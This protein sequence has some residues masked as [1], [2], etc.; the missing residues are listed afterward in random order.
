MHG[1]PKPGGD[2]PVDQLAQ[3][4]VAAVR[5]VGK[6]ASAAVASVIGD[7][8]A[9]ASENASAIRELIEDEAEES[10]GLAKLVTEMA[11]DFFLRK[12]AQSS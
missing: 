1:V 11:H 5:E 9:K 2:S 10:D 4:W 8:Q 3:R 12:L 6:A 7:E